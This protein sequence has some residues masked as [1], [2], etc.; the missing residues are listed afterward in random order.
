MHTRLAYAHRP[1]S[2]ASGTFLR[3]TRYTNVTFVNTVN[4][5]ILTN[6]PELLRYACVSYRG[7]LPVC[8]QEYRTSTL[9]TLLYVFVLAIEIR[10]GK[11]VSIFWYWCIACVPITNGSDN[12]PEIKK[13]FAQSAPSPLKH[14]PHFLTCSMLSYVSQ[15]T[16]ND[17]L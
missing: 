8:R 3:Q 15:R 2:S 1:P 4:G 7:V 10:D 9:C 17:S 13:R 14:I 16:T 12:W 11:C 5:Q 6:A